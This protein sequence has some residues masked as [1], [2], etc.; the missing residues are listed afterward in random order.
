MVQPLK[1]RR[2]SYQFETNTL[3]RINRMVSEDNS[4]NPE[5]RVKICSKFSELIALFNEQTVERLRQTTK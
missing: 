2:G 4:I 3:Q 1:P 5:V